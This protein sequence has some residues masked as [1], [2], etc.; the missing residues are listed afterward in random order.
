MNDDRLRAAYGAA[1]RSGIAGGNTH[2]SPEAFAAIVRREGPESERLATLDHVMSCLDCR[3]DFDLLRVVE[4]AG[5]Q[6]GAARGS[7]R[8][9]WLMPAALAASV[10]VAVGL[11]RLVLKPAGDEVTRGVETGAPTLLSPAAEV[12]A[13]GAIA[14]VWSSAPGARKY[15]V[16]MLDVGGGV[17]ASAETTDTTATP[18]ATSTLPAGDYT[19]WVRATTLDARTL[20][21]AVRPL[22]LT[23]K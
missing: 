16:E 6:V 20:R 18:R 17:V 7:G 19:W 23:E 8:P 5:R 2:A 9:T 1:L 11:G 22:R 21:S 10:L 15:I 3:R 14:F 4:Q 13:G 12:A